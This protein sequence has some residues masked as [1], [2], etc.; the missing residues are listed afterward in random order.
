MMTENPVEIPGAHSFRPVLDQRAD[1]GFVL[2][3]VVADTHF[4][5]L[6]RSP[7]GNRPPIHSLWLM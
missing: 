3:P 6:R 1:R 5:L 4:E 2:C 7:P